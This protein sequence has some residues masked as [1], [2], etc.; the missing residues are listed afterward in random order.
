MNLRFRGLIESKAY[1]GGVSD[2]AFWLEGG[3]PGPSAWN[4]YK[5]EISDPPQVFFLNNNRTAPNRDQTY[6]IEYTKELKVEGGAVVTLS[7]D[8]R[9]AEQVINRQKYPGL[10]AR[11]F[12]QFIQMNVIGISPELK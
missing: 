7:T 2:G 6:R 5:L 8:A 12:T 1:S 4:V 11:P 10:N 3:Q 9:D